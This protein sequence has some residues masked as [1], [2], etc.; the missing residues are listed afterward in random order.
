MSLGL[1][2]DVTKFLAPS[3]RRVPLP[4]YAFQHQRYFLDRVVIRDDDSNAAVIPIRRED[5]ATWGYRP[6]WKQSLVEVSEDTPVTEA[7]SERWLVFST[8]A[9]LGLRSS[10]AFVAVVTL[11]LRSRWGI[12][13]VAVERCLHAVSGSRRD[14]YESSSGSSQLNSGFRTGSLTFG[15]S[16]RTGLIA[17]VE[18]LP[19]QSRAR[20]LLSSVPG[21][22]SI[23]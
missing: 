9:A 18:L 13:S 11:S 23:Q 5:R 1:P 21:P 12:H 3:G 14:E 4:T 15:S 7:I 16:R 17:R 8:M 22:G 19:S 6:V 2:L 20:L 10:T